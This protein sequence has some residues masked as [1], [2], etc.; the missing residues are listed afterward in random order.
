MRF[1]I[2]RTYAGVTG[3]ELK[4][5]P[6]NNQ[7]QTQEVRGASPEEEV[8]SGSD[9][10]V[11]RILSYRG[12]ADLRFGNPKTVITELGVLHRLICDVIPNQQTLS[13][14][15]AQLTV[16]AVGLNELPCHGRRDDAGRGRPATRDIHLGVTED[17]LGRD[18]ARGSPRHTDSYDH[19]EGRLHGS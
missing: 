16:H 7:R 6:P 8:F 19:K 14:G 5:E 15:K 3:D 10:H 13:T 9:V 12:I 18:I 4:G 1:S 11:A 17:S 2:Q